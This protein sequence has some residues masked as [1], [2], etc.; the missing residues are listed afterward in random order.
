MTPPFLVCPGCRTLGDEGLSV[1]TLDRLG[2]VLRCACGRRYPIVDG[3]PIVMA[4]PTGYLVNEMAA[5]VERDLSPE[6]AA[7]LAETG[8]DD[9]PYA[10]MLEHLSIYLDAHWGDRAQPPPDGPTSPLAATALAERVAGRRAHRV[11]AAVELGCSVG[12]IVAELAAGADHVVGIDLQ[13]GAVRRARRLVAGEALPYCRRL[14]GR[15]YLAATAQAGELSVPAERVTWLCGDVLNPPLVP[16]Q[17]QRVVAFNVLDSVKRPRQ[18]LSVIDALCELG[19]E[20]LLS[21][22]YAWQSGVV[23]EDARLGGVDPA[24]DLIAL[25][26]SGEGLSGR[27]DLEDQAQLPWTLRKDAR[28]AVT[29]AVHYLRAR[30]IAPVA[31]S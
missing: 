8:P 2:E 14:V 29:Y 3:I 4:D 28:S 1:R 10:R 24:A 25:L 18:L 17:Y 13:F 20:I 7:L 11:E 15:H 16:Q 12:R 6:V 19:G 21:S 5:V 23:D 22:P 31:A 30:K 9:A 26:R 27:Y